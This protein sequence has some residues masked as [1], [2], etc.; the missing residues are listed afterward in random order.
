MNCSGFLL[1][2]QSDGEPVCF[3]VTFVTF[4]ALHLLHN[5]HHIHYY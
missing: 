3:T 5:I 1:A 2:E 4:D